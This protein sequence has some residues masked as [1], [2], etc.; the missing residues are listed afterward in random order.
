LSTIVH[1]IDDDAGFRTAVGRLLKAIGYQVA[2]Y[3]SATELLEKLPDD[4]EPS[5]ILLDVEMPCLSGPELQDRLKKKGSTLPI[6]FLTGHPDISTSVQTI[7]AGADDFLVKPVGKEKLLEAIE[8]AI[9]RH[10]ETQEHLGRIN[11]LQTRIS[12]LTPREN[13]VFHLVIREQLNKQIAYQ[14]GV[15][16]RTVK[17]HRHQVMK[18]LQVKTL[19]ELVSVAEQ[20]GILKK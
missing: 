15:S 8:N 12:A 18:K 11:V 14:L 20:V 5:C 1:I 10:R 3:E 9:S 2:L 13:E 16:Q 19:V 17:A 6:V 7:K 4:K